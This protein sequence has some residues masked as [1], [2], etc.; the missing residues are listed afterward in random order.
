MILESKPIAEL[1][2]LNVKMASVNI[3]EH[4]LITK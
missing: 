4:S 2:F 1:H 3:N